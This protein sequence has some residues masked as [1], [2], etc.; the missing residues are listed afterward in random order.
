M[1]LS[2]C[3]EM[4]F[5]AAHSLP[6]YNGLCANLH[7]HRWVLEVEVSRD[8]QDLADDM[9]IDFVQ[10]KLIMQSEIIDKFDHQHINEIFHNGRPTAENMVRHFVDTIGWHFREHFDSFANCQL[11][12]IRLYESPSSFCEWRRS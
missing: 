11:E 9:V 5:A 4:S 7:G 3:K 6:G 1:R 12:R 2:V 10:L 8:L